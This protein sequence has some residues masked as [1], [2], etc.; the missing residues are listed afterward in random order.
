MIEI[1]FIT[2]F[3]IAFIIFLLIPGSGLL[4][5][6]LFAGRKSRANQKGKTGNMHAYVERLS[7]IENRIKNIETIMSD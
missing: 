6:A 1:F 4:L 2:C 5:I 3:V 7:G